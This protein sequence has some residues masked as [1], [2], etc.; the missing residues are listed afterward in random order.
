MWIKGS[1]TVEAAIIIP[2]FIFIMAVSIRAGIKLYQDITLQ[3]EQKIV[4]NMWVVDD[5]YRY[6]LGKEVITK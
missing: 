5:F 3:T 4:E 1:Y 2:I 6:Q